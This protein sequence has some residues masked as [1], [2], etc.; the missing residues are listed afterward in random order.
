MTKRGD[1]ESAR[2][3]FERLLE[4]A[5]GEL[6]YRGTATESMLAAKQAPAALQFAEQ[7]LHKAREKNDRDSEQYF[8][9]LIAAAR[10][11]AG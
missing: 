2:D 6:R 11:Q 3:V 5:P 7:G 8:M 4:R 10:K 9:E 1:I